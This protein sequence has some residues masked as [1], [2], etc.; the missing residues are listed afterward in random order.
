MPTACSQWSHLHL[1]YESSF[2]PLN[3]WGAGLASLDSQGLRL[4]LLCELHHK[5]AST[6]AASRGIW[7]P[8]ITACLLGLP[9]GKASSKGCASSFLPW[10]ALPQC[11][12]PHSGQLHSFCCVVSLLISFHSSL[13]QTEV[14]SNTAQNVACAPRLGI[15]G[16]Q[17]TDRTG[18]GDGCGWYNLLRCSIGVLH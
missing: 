16:L 10:A 18:P 13:T 11:F 7:P 1:S 12:T 17:E 15:L 8:V 2:W 6:W 4:S 5:C 14:A 3:G 9:R